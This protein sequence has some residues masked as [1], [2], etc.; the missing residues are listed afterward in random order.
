VAAP[1]LLILDNLVVSAEELHFFLLIVE[2]LTGDNLLATVL[3]DLVLIDKVIRT[4]SSFDLLAG[5]E[6]D[7]EHTVLVQVGLPRGAGWPELREVV[8]H[9]AVIVTLVYRCVN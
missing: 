6:V 3:P 1:E 4:I 2:L 8:H 9:W 7:Q 5:S